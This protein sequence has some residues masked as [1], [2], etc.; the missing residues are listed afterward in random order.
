[1]LTSSVAENSVYCRVPFGVSR[2]LLRPKCLQRFSSSQSPW[3]EFQCTLET[4][5]RERP[6]PE[7]RIRVAEA[8]VVGRVV[9]KEGHGKLEHLRSG[10]R[11]A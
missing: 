1:M 3:I 11:L 7:R 6:F 8:E 9:W 2:D 4:L 10:S 5:D